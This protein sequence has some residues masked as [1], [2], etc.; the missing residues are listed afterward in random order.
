MFQ[1]LVRVPAQTP[2]YK[3]HVVYISRIKMKRAGNP[4]FLNCPGEFR[5]RPLIKVGQINVRPKARMGRTL[6]QPVGCERAIGFL[7]SIAE[8]N[9]VAP[10]NPVYEP[11]E[12][13]FHL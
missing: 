3:T 12:S 13:G 5:D 9:I 4:L 11:F 8:L 1:E 7:T 2:K 10:K 6:W